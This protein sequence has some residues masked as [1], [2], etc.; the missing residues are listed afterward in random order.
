MRINKRY[1]VDEDGNPK[2]VV[3]LLEDFK[4]NVLHL[5]TQNPLNSPGVKPMAGEWPGY[6]RIRSGK[7]RI[8][9]WY[10]DKADLVYV[11]YIGT[12]GDVYK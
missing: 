11:D 12:R 6:R 4:K 9:Y 3:I 5:L 10:D 1:I 8:I 2:E 7:Y